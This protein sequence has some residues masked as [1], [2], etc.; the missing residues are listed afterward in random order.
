MV[1]RFISPMYGT[2]SRVL[3][4]KSRCDMVDKEN[5][6]VISIKINVSSVRKV[7]ERI[8]ELTLKNVHS[9]V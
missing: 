7:T 6:K 1:G 2:F 9:F 8:L 3:R 4:V 5:S